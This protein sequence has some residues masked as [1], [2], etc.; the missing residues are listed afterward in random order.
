MDDLDRAREEL[1]RQRAKVEARSSKA[2]GLAD[3]F[4]RQ[5]EENGWRVVVEQIVKGQE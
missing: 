4:R 3:W 2:S 5:R 1:R